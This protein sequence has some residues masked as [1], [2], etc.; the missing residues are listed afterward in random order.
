MDDR[1]GREIFRTYS[2]KDAFAPAWAVRTVGVFLECA[3]H[4][5]A[6]ERHAEHRDA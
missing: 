6:Y 1:C 3:M 2:V 4:A 5:G